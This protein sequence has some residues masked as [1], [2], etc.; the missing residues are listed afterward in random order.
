MVWLQKAL[1]VSTVILGMSMMGTVHPPAGA[2]CLVFIGAH[3]KGGSDERV[4]K[5]NSALD[6]SHH[7]TSDQIRC[8]TFLTDHIDV[9]SLTDPFV[10]RTIFVGALNKRVSDK[11]SIKVFFNSLDVSDQIRSDRMDHFTDHTNVFHRSLVPRTNSSRV[12]RGGSE[13]C[14][15]KL[16]TRWMCQIRSA[17][18]NPLCVVFIKYPW[19]GLNS[20]LRVQGLTRTLFELFSHCPYVRCRADVAFTGR[21]ALSEQVS[22][23]PYLVQRTRGFSCFFTGRSASYERA[24]KTSDHCTSTDISHG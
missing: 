15:M 4:K 6:R 12:T 13:E 8:I 11:H 23:R 5:K 7:I 9:F 1:T 19:R 16:L 17:F 22:K 18:T 21:W 10:P 20:R 2:L 3:N 24:S 14:L